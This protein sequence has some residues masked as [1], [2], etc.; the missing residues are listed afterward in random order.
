MT[1]ADHHAGYRQPVV[2]RTPRGKDNNTEQ[3]QRN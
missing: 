2:D 3:M 1:V